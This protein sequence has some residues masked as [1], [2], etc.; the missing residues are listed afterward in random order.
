MYCDNY[1]HEGLVYWY[2]DVKE[3]HDEIN[4]KTKNKKK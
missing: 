4:S 3:Q 1:D 2:E